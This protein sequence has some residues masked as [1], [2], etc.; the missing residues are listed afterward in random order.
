MKKINILTIVVFFAISA[1]SQTDLHQDAFIKEKYQSAAKIDEVKFKEAY[2]TTKQS[3]RS[4]SVA[5]DVIWSNTFSDAS[6]WTIQ[7]SGVLSNTMQ[8]GA[9]DAYNCYLLAYVNAGY[10]ASDVTPNFETASDG[11]AQFYG[12]C[13]TDT[14]GHEISLKYNETIDLSAVSRASLKLS[15]YMRKWYDN[16][17]VVASNSQGVS[18]T[19]EILNGYNNSDYTNNPV[20]IIVPINNVSGDSDVS[21]EIIYEQPNYSGYFFMMDDI[22]IEDN[23]IGL[24]VN[25]KLV[26]KKVENI[27]LELTASNVFFQSGTGSGSSDCD[28]DPLYI[29]IGGYYGAAPSKHIQFIN[30]LSEAFS[31]SGSSVFN[32]VSELLSDF[33]D[34]MLDIGVYD[35]KVGN[36]T[37]NPYPNCSVQ[38]EDCFEVV[39]FSVDAVRGNFCNGGIIY[40]DYTNNAVSS[41]NQDN[42]FSVNLVN[43]FSSNDDVFIR[44]DT[45]VIGSLS[46]VN[47][48]TITCNL[49]ELV[50]DDNEQVSSS[51]FITG[52]KPSFRSE[53]KS[54]PFYNATNIN[55]PEI[56]Y[57]TVNQDG[58]NEI[59]WSSIQLIN[60][61]YINIYKE[62][63]A[64]GVYDSVA[65]ISLN[66]SSFIDS[67]SSPERKSSTYVIT[68]SD[69][70]DKLSQFSLPHKTM[71]LT[72][73]T[74][75]NDSW[76][77][78]WSHYEGTQLTTYKIWRGTN[79][80]NLAVID[81]VSGSIYTYS[82]L[83]PPSGLL[84]YQ[85]EAIVP[86]C[87]I[88]RSANYTSLMS[89]VTENS[90]HASDGH[91]DT[92]LFYDT[93]TII[94]TIEVIFNDTST[95]YE[96]EYD[97]IT[98]VD[99]DTLS[100]YDTII[101]SEGDTQILTIYNID[102]VITQVF[103]TIEVTV[104]N[105]ISVFDTIIIEI[106]DTNT[107]YLTV[108]DTTYVSVDDT[109]IIKMSV[110]TSSGLDNEL[111]NE[112]SIYP[113]P[114]NEILN[115]NIA[116]SGDYQV[117]L[118]N[119][120][121]Q[122]LHIQNNI[123]DNTQIDISAIPVGLYYII[124]KDNQSIFNDS[125]IKIV[126]E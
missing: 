79:P 87:N 69:S 29:G 115:I 117:I 54:L 68:C 85:I 2:K 99:Y 101:I 116:S 105:Q 50:V 76:N 118:N 39:D 81:S 6:E 66:S 40:V 30:S 5:G 62:S 111:Y 80:S 82:D 98:V 49:P 59:F 91:T 92:L 83:S 113:N 119:S 96:Y 42:T 109:L 55:N 20:E 12:W 108:Y 35:V 52:D 19:I 77:L 31:F 63:S 48:N 34:Y 1:F 7:T 61:E 94:D 36:E 126:V 14:N 18:D 44:Y 64:I 28:S 10:S 89:N 33:I 38:C 93:I 107:S 53:Y 88:T 4:T 125:Q 27:T 100:S 112:V 78:I 26:G 56:C 41:F 120:N 84:Y 70:C 122:I 123:T 72:L 17:Y 71:H 9:F 95:I 21:L 121:G 24:S 51:I 3:I 110:T 43:T 102:T 32:S 8:I 15:V 67:S 47:S 22:S 97:T 75:Q 103:D 114:A 58:F 124:I 65:S 13:E 90:F 57:V 106:Y 46:D 86:I 37:I 23:S 11:I 60:I 74:G 25:P 16:I 104:T 73:N 45:T